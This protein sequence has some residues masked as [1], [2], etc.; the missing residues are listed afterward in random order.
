MHAN[1]PEDF[2]C[3]WRQ[4]S[5]SSNPPP[6]ARTNYF[7]KEMDKIKEVFAKYADEKSCSHLTLVMTQNANESLHSTI[8]NICPKAKY[9]SPQSVTIITAV[10][11]TIF[12]E[13]ELSIF[14]FM[15]DFQLKPTYL[16][17]RSI[18]KRTET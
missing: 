16:S 11:V 18:I 9:V 5:G 15:K 8:W 10:A 7:P 14:G 17:F 3:R 12:N 4:T 2:S 13:G 1:C 6:T